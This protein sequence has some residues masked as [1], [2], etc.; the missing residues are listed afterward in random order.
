MRSASAGATIG[1]EDRK[2]SRALTGPD[3]IP[4]YGERVLGSCRGHLSRVRTIRSWDRV[5]LT[6]SWS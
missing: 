5:T 6:P 3:T 2:D 4:A 1:G